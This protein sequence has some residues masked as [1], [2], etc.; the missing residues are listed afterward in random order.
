MD[1][2]WIRSGHKTDPLWIQGGPKVDLMTI[3]PFLVY[4]NHFQFQALLTHQHN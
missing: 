3:I 4:N 2:K 1:T